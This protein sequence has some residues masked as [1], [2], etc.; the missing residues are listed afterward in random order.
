MWNVR[1]SST[2]SNKLVDCRRAIKKG[3]WYFITQFSAFHLI[4]RSFIFFNYVCIDYKHLTI[5]YIL[6]CRHMTKNVCV[7][8]CV[9]TLKLNTAAGRNSWIF[10]FRFLFCC[11]SLILGCKKKC[12]IRAFGWRLTVVE[13]SRKGTTIFERTKK[14]KTSNVEMAWCIF[15]LTSSRYQDFG[16][17]EIVTERTGLRENDERTKRM[18]QQNK[19]IENK[20]WYIIK[21]M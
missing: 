1:S 16:L 14:K 21:Q 19:T 20:N 4:L 2:L 15:R 13:G 7:R 9:K 11:C 17:E 8:K 6:L 3:V 5:P 18:K 12:D 10:V